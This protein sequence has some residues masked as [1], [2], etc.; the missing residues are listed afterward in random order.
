MFFHESFVP[1]LFP[2]K[3]GE[4]EA[5]FWRSVSTAS[6][7]VYGVLGRISCKKLQAQT[8]ITKGPYSDGSS[9]QEILKANSKKSK[10]DCNCRSVTLNLLNLPSPPPYIW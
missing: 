1:K 7:P 5:I 3:F 8:Y 9:E 4:Y 6:T 10:V 2:V